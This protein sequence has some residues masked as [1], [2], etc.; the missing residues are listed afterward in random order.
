MKLVKKCNKDPVV[1]CEYKRYV[2]INGKA[3]KACGN[4]MK[5]PLERKK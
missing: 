2:F 5:C 4:K 1:K 3:V